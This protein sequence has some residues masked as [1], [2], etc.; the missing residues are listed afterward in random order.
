MR[1]TDFASRLGV[2]VDTVRRLEQQR[3]LSP[4][5]DWA[6]HR[7]Y[8]QADLERAEHHLFPTRSDRQKAK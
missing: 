3:I 2:S 6:G 7:R 1:I 8:S 4:Q 5:R